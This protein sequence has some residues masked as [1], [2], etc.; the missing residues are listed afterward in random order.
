[1]GST[2]ASG[3]SVEHP[4]TARSVR[5]HTSVLRTVREEN[6]TENFALLS[7]VSGDYLVQYTGGNEHYTF[8]SQS[9]AYVIPLC[10]QTCRRR[11][12]RRE[13]DRTT[14]CS[15]VG[16]PLLMTR[17]LERTPLT[18]TDDTTCLAQ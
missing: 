18:K 1:M 4:E 16:E 2:S 7:I 3:G 9:A 6:W 15:R 17:D 11:R 13:V 5:H 10:K 14:R 12:R 8:H